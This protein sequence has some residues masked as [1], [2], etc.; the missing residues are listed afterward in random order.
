MASQREFSLLVKIMGAMDPSLSNATNLTKRQLQSFKN[1]IDGIDK[2]LWGG[3]TKAAKV[4]LA[5]ATAAGTAT[6]VVGK[7]MVDVGSE[8]DQY[9]KLMGWT[10][11]EE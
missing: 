1:T 10:K 5:A 7:K 8:L 6:V 3:L 2:A 11:T 4:G 9:L